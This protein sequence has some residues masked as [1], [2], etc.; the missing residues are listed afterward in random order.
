MGALLCTET[1]GDRLSNIM[2]S[3]DHLDA[4]MRAF[5]GRDT[6]GQIS[7]DS[8]GSRAVR[9]CM[10]AKLCILPSSNLLNRRLSPERI[11]LPERGTVCPPGAASL[12]TTSRTRQPKRNRK[13]D[14]GA[15]DSVAPESV[16]HSALDHG[17]T[18][19]VGWVLSFVQRRVGTVF[20]I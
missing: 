11:P 2:R 16:F 15:T 12:V 8:R 4:P 10:S 17:I 14:S 5:L 18:S 9:C 7:R 20:P 6:C 13:T 19:T 1:R 3:C